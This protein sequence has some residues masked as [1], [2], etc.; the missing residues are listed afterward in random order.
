MCRTGGI[1]STKRARIMQNER[2]VSVKKDAG[3]YW[4]HDGLGA[5]R[6]MSGRGGPTGTERAREEIHQ[7]HDRSYRREERLVKFDLFAAHMQATSSKRL[8]MQKLD[9]PSLSLQSEP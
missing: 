6:S 1:V 9:P 5:P 8:P 2:A 4:Q 3:S 7:Q